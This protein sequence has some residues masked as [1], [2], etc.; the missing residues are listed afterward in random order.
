MGT[1]G[2]IKRVPT[3]IERAAARRQALR[4]EEEVG[5][6]EDRAVGRSK[7]K[8]TSK[9]MVEII[10]KIKTTSINARDLVSCMALISIATFAAMAQEQDAAID[11]MEIAKQVSESRAANQKLMMTYSWTKRTEL[12]M[13]G[14]TKV[15][16]TE[17]VHFAPGGKLVTSPV[18]EEK[19]GRKKRGIRG[20]IVKKKQEGMR[21]W[22]GELTKLLAEYRLPTT[23]KLLDYISAAEID[24]NSRD[25]HIKVKGTDVIKPGDSLVYVLDKNTRE[26]LHVRI[27]TRLGEDPVVVN[28]IYRELDSGLAYPS[29]QTIEVPGKKIKMNVQ[30]FAYIQ[31]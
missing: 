17:M 29:D 26:L 24:R 31:N 8:V 12:I 7:R 2:P 10:M 5:D 22:L 20:R 21:D 30:T 13:K 1:T 23:G 4:E 15:L 25:K 11:S 16:K 18:G 6:V 28:T 9:W 19:K 27:D 14:E 3:T